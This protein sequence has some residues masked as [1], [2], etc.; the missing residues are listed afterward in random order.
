MTGC[1][2]SAVASVLQRRRN[3]RETDLQG[4]GEFGGGLVPELAGHAVVAG[5]V[6]L[7]AGGRG[8]CGTGDCQCQDD[9]PGAPNGATSCGPGVHGSSTRH[10]PPSLAWMP[11][12][13]HSGESRLPQSGDVDLQIRAGWEPPAIRIGGRTH[14]IEQLPAPD[15]P[16]HDA[17]LRTW[18]RPLRKCRQNGAIGRRLGGLDRPARRLFLVGQAVSLRAHGMG[19][20]FPDLRAA[21]TDPIE[22]EFCVGGTPVNAAA[23][24]PATISR[25]PGPT[26]F[27]RTRFP[28]AGRRP[29]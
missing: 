13:Q 4:S 23:A 24:H 2:P 9:D 16:L 22:T 10:H 14:S 28:H 19:V 21:Q 6:L 29:G 18:F 20:A 7:M 8:D 15:C 1:D 25:R 11:L 27:P 17:V 5:C 12:A 26:G 3:V